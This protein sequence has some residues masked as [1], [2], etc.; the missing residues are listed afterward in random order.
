MGSP[1]SP[2]PSGML[3]AGLVVAVLILA[4]RLTGFAREWLIAVKAGASEATDIAIVLL[5]FPDLMVSLLLGGGLAAALVPAFKRLGRGGENALFLQVARLVGI[6]FALVA[7]M[8]AILAP[9]VLGLL[10]PGLSPGL[11]D[12]HANHFRLVTVALPL[13]ALSGVTVA[14]LNANG[15]F[16]VGASGTLIFNLTVIACLLLANASETVTAIAIG[17]VAGSL[18]RLLMQSSGLRRDWRLPST[19][20][21]LIDGVLVR[22]FLAS[23]GFIT[24]L[25]LLPPLARAVASF[26]DAG[27]L[28][29]FNYA[30]KLVELPMGVVIGS[31]STV[32]LPRLAADFA[33]GGMATAQ[34][35]LSAGLRAALLISVGI[36]I[37]AAVFADTLVQLA[38][39]KASFTPEQLRALSQL[40]A[41]GFLSLPFQGLLNI[42]GSAFAASGHT[43][44][45][46]ASALFMLGAIAVAA[47]V[48]QAILGLPG[49]MLAYAGVYLLGALLLSWRAYVHFGANTLASALQNAPKTLIVPALFATIVALF[50]DQVGEGLFARAA[51]AV[52]VFG[53]F[54]TS[55]VL[56]DARLREHLLG[57]AKRNGN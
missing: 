1:A 26:G 40:A 7:A 32:L 51:W 42:Y 44:P 22:R 45:L 49:V 36:A 35:S 13:A 46:V 6:V 15:R 57:L 55:A 47:P 16:A 4:G 10:A 11:T 3:R 34:A 25:V 5:T 29:L 17:A 9:Q 53:I 18:L 38:F 24:I 8:L 14:L 2:P 50:G 39:F 54:M 43:R 28:S 52:A 20:A 33:Q 48:A 31:I 23:F 12:S 56:L 30:H 37:P 21:G 41:I 27:S 19:R